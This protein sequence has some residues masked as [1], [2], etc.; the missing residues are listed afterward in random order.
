MTPDEATA[1]IWRWVRSVVDLSIPVLRRDDNQAARGPLYVVVGQVSDEPDGPDDDLP[2]PDGKV[3]R[4]T[5]RRFRSQ[6]DVV[7]SGSRSLAAQIQMLWRSTA[8]PDEVGVESSA[9]PTIRNLGLTGA[10]AAVVA[11]VDLLGYYRMTLA[12]ADAPGELVDEVRIELDTVIP[13]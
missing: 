7:G 1:A 10:S 5:H 3:A 4:S 11:I 9:G 6:I 8:G 13:P 12:E 2:R